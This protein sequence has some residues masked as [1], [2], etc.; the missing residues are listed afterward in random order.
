MILQQDP[1]HKPV[2]DEEQRYHDRRNEVGG[3]QLPRLEPDSIALIERV[4]EIRTAPKVEHPDQDDSQPTLQACQCKQ[5]QNR[6]NEITVRS[7]AREIG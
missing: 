3:T 5:G 2:C 4:E 1:K 6:G 7:W